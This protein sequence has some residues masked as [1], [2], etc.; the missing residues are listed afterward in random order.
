[1]PTIL[2]ISDLHVG[3]G[4]HQGKWNAI[5]DTIDHYKSYPDLIVITGDVVNSPWRHQLKKAYLL[6]DQLKEKLAKVSNKNVEVAFVPG[7]HDTRFSGLVPISYF[8]V[9]A[10]AS[11]LTWAVIIGM[12]FS[13]GQEDPASLIFQPA[14]G[15][16]LAGVS[17][18]LFRALMTSRIEEIFRNFQVDGLKRYP[19]MGIGIIAFD[20]A[21]MP[22]FG[23]HGRFPDSGLSKIHEVRVAQRGGAGGDD[24]P[25]DLFWIAAV[26]HHVLPLPHDSSYEF[27][28]VMENAGTMLYELAGKD[29]PLILHG[30][31]HHHH[32]ARALLRDANG[33]EHDISVLSA[34]TPTESRNVG[35]FGHSFNIIHVE[36]DL[37]AS[38][39]VCRSAADGVFGMS[40]PVSITSPDVIAGRKYARYKRDCQ[41]FCDKMFGSVSID[42]FGNARLA[43]E[44][45]G[46]RSRQAL[47]SMSH[48]FRF[49]SDC[50]AIAATFGGAKGQH[51]SAIWVEHGFRSPHLAV[52]TVNFSEPLLPASEGIS[53]SLGTEVENAIALDSRQFEHMHPGKHDN[54]EYVGQVV[55]AN[56]AVKELLLE[57]RFPPLVPVPSSIKLSMTLKLGAD[58]AWLEMS[59]SDFEVIETSRAVYAK[60]KSPAPGSA[61]RFSWHVPSRDNIVTHHED[62][63]VKR[64]NGRQN[65]LVNFLDELFE[66]VCQVLVKDAD[67]FEAGYL[68]DQVSAILYCYSRSE[69]KLKNIAALGNDV[70]CIGKDEHRYG[71]GL[72]GQSYK[73]GIIMVCDPGSSKAVSDRSKLGNY[74]F[75][76]AAEE[77]GAGRPRPECGSGMA[78]P[79]FAVD[80]DNNIVSDGDP[81]AVVQLSFGKLGD[82]VKLTD[83]EN[84]SS[85]TKFQRAVC[86]M[87]CALVNH[88]GNGKRDG[89]RS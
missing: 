41:A 89:G 27:T 1:M 8:T 71:I 86:A 32:F 36:K 33:I 34:G 21:S 9:L 22:K 57:L 13:A 37:N 81:F 26:H 11:I 75:N 44:F 52:S 50:G 56:V 63:L 77:I 69:G 70:N 30:H 23:A 80:K 17:L 73:N 7:N 65:D 49:Q 59:S 4:F 78:V 31:K 3:R 62:L 82:K 18:F 19:A 51:A 16:L 45:S 2:H 83:T 67:Q 39:R 25:D 61:Y 10:W 5:F 76:P 24:E 38:F 6:V 47:E 60:I 84:D 58:A 79:I 66:L 87:L 68:E 29:I 40:S 74:R 14:L 46:F 43:K 53:F 54:V 35:E 12:R 55:P 28:M 48:D 64:L 72:A 85:T 88:A 15:L 20:S 42:E